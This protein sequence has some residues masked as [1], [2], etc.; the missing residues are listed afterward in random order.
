MKKSPT[1][2]RTTKVKESPEA[3]LLLKFSN[4]CGVKTTIQ[5]VMEIAPRMEEKLSAV[6]DIGGISSF[7][8][9]CFFFY[10]FYYLLL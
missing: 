10:F 2:Q 3:L 4:I 6:S 1:S 7:P 5:A 8:V 9:K